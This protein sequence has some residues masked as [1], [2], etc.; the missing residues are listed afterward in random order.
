[1][2]TLIVHNENVIMKQLLSLKLFISLTILIF[3]IYSCKKISYNTGNGEIIG[4]DVRTCIC[5]GGTEITIDNAT[6]PNGR[7]Y[8]LIASM[9]SSFKIADNEKFPIPVTVDWRIDNAH[10]SGNYIE[11]KKISRR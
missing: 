11:I 7:Q 4:Y 5:C 8:F 3:T 10:C 2:A 6:Y 9:P 1:V